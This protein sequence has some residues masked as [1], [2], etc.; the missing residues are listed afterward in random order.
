MLPPIPSA[1]ETCAGVSSPHATRVSTS[2]CS[3][4]RSASIRRSGPVSASASATSSTRPSGSS[5]GPVL[6]CSRVH[7]RN[8]RSSVRTCLRT[9]FAATPYSHA[10]VASGSRGLPARSC[11]STRNASA[12]KSS[13]ISTPT[14]RARHRCSR[15][16]VPEWS[17]STAS[18]SRRPA[19]TSP[20][21]A[22]ALLRTP[23]PA[24][25]HPPNASHSA[26][27]TPPGSRSRC[28]ARRI[29]ELPAQAIPPMRPGSSG[30]PNQQRAL[31]D[32]ASSNPSAPPPANT[33][34]APAADLRSP[35][36]RNTSG[37]SSAAATSPVGAPRRHTGR[38]AGQSGATSAIRN[39]LTCP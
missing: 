2:R 39:R 24:R 18:S 13:A 10:A 29:E 22:V 37:V 20:G 7:A 19:R 3:R 5:S 21:E 1:A 26:G 17:R 28:S 30:A 23:L 14:R 38:S 15:P 8:R 31:S 33:P 11:H 12:T 25:A 27:S 9:R 16:A 36:A 34:A 35:R 6:A 32:G 4:G